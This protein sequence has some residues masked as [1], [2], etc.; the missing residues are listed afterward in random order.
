MVLEN[1]TLEIARPRVAVNW[2][3]A[4]KFIF[5]PFILLAFA[6]SRFE[7]TR[8]ENPARFQWAKLT[9]LL[10]MW[11]WFFEASHRK[12]FSD[13]AYGENVIIVRL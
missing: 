9:V 3:Y 5:L 2:A 12:G 10:I 11:R 4:K 7:Q 6:E 13:L 8:W 1:G